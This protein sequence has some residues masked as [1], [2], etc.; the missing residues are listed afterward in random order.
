MTTINVTP[1]NTLGSVAVVLA[2]IPQAG[3]TILNSGAETGTEGWTAFGGSTT[4]TRVAGG[5]DAAG[6]WKFSLN[7]ATGQAAGVTGAQVTL[8]GLQVGSVY[9][10]SAV[11]N[12]ATASPHVQLTVQGIGSSGTAS[13]TKDAIQ[14]ISFQFTATATSHVLRI[15]NSATSSTGSTLFDSVLVT[16]VTGA[17]KT[18]TRTD[19]A[20]ASSLIFPTVTAG[21]ASFTDYPTPGAVSY[22]VFDGFATVG[23][24]T[25]VACDSIRLGTNSGSLRVVVSKLLAQYDG[26][27]DA[28]ST[29]HKILGRSDPIV[30]LKAMGTRTGSIKI[31]CDTLTIA[32]SIESMCAAGEVMLLQVPSTVSYAATSVRFAPTGTSLEYLTDTNKWIVTIGYIEVKA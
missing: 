29:V 13:T 30:T 14:T 8:T 5:L 11:V 2:Q 4:V 24:A 16:T 3:G 22:S 19:A 27:R 21:A 31:G 17:S 6:S 28:A 26:A 12:P 20:G 32:R 15:A 18:I 9:A 25:T 10:A 23:A 7:F 1:N